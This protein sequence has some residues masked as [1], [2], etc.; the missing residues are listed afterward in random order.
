MFIERQRKVLNRLLD[1][2]P[3]QFEGGLN[4]RKY[5][6]LANTSK[7]TATRDL[8]EMVQLGCLVSLGMG[9]RSTS[10]DLPWDDLMR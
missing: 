10:Y 4:A 2:G 3:G 7:P 5:E 8:A 6:K 1:A 9:G